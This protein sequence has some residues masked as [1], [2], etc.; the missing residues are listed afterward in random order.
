MPNCN[1]RDAV[2]ML[3][4]VEKVRSTYSAPSAEVTESVRAEDYQI[5]SLEAL[6]GMKM[7]SFRDK[8]GMQLRD[9]LDLG[10]VHA[11]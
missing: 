6:A 4:A 9:L 2:Q 5:L 8:D 11:F 1:P 10:L 7:N 3:Y